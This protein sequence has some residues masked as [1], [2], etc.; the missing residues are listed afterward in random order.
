MFE[1]ILLPV[2]DGEWSLRA[3]EMLPLLAAPQ[4]RI[5]LLHVLPRSEDTESQ[6]PQ[7]GAG[8][9][10]LQERVTQIH[11]FGDWKVVPE[12]ATGDLVEVLEER[13]ASFEPDLTLMGSQ[14]RKGLARWIFGSV[15]ARFVKS[16]PCP[17]LV[18][19]PE[20]RSF[21][22][23]DRV[24]LA[25]DFSDYARAARDAVLRLAQDMTERETRELYVLHV[26]EDGVSEGRAQEDMDRELAEMRE[27]GLEGVGRVAEG[28]ASVC[29]EALVNEVGAQ[30]VVLGTQ[31]GAEHERGWLGSTMDR[32]LSRVTSPVLV[33]PAP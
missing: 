6:L 24:V 9:K 2:D 17:I 26:F 18:V 11:E 33:V 15:A 27:L 20:G 19:K 23:L 8:R 16:C 7:R 32:T 5:E 4:A 25:T 12:L 29:I 10:L 14:G 31:G 22:R 3:I 13:V 21:S 30:L 28:D 1:R